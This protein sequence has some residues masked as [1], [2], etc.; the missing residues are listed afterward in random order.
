MN[1]EIFYHMYCVNDCV[2]R[3]I[4]TYNKI[5]ESGLLKICNSVNVVL[6][7][8]DK[9]RRYE[10]RINFLDKVKTT[11][12]SSDTKGEMNTLRTIQSFCQSAQDSHILYLHSK[13]ASRGKNQNIESWVNYM[14]YFSIEKHLICLEKLREYDT[15]GV[16]LHAE[17]MKHYSGNFWWANSTYIKTLPTFEEGLKSG[18]VND[19]I[20]YC[21]FW[22]MNTT[23]N[24]CNPYNLHTAGKDL[25]ANAYEESNYKL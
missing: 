17:P 18:S 7:G 21:E 14:E 1:I 20:W 11:C 13:G 8:D 3:F 12:F 15:V 23:H 9:L 6:V 4:K 16:E 2:D 5:K 24:P 25:Y 19:P 22:L 10:S